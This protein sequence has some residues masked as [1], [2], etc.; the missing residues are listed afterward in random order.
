M[1]KLLEQ[2]HGVMKAIR[3]LNDNPD[4][5]LHIVIS[6]SLL[7]ILYYYLEL[8]YMV[9]LL[10]TIGIGIIK[11]L[12]DKYNI[13]GFSRQNVIANIIGIIIGSLFILLKIIILQIF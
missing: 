12:Y 6:F 10:L 9:A 7:I 11:E 8:S 3:Y 1:M 5:L 13:I 2:I 4:K